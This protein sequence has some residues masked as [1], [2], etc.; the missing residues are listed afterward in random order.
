MS[1]STDNDMLGV[2]LQL[3]VSVAHDAAVVAAVGEIDMATVP[4][5]REAVSGVLDNDAVPALLV[6]DLREVSFLASA[7]LALLVEIANA[8]EVRDAA[9]RIVAITPPVLRAFEVT[10]LDDRLA[11]YDTLVEALAA[12]RR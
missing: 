10:G 6:I 12:P 4:H 7:G 11:I 8:T 2:G 3:T 9:L 5:L 1:D